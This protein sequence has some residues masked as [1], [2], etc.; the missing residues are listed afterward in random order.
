[1]PSLN[2]S[3]V[4]LAAVLGLGTAQARAG[5][6]ADHGYPNKPVRFLVPYA[7]G[8]GTDMMARYMAQKLAG[9]LAAPVIVDNR[10]GGGGLVG[11]ETAVR[12]APDGYTLVFDSAAYAT[13]AA[14]HEL[15]FDPLKDITPVA[16]AFTSGFIVSLH[17]SVPA[18]SVKELIAYAN[19]QQGKVNYGSSGVG[20]FSHLA[21][22]LFL[23]M[24]KTRMNHIAYRGTG[25]AVADLLGGQIQVVWG[26]LTSVVAQIKSQRLRGIAVTMGKRWNE[27]PDLPTVG[28]TVPNYEASVWYGIWG[29]RNLPPAIVSRINREARQIAQLPE[30]AERM[31]SEGVDAFIATPDQFRSLIATDLS[32][33]G[34]VVRATGLKEAVK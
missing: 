17:P 9:V 4:F 1:M 30:T 26:T 31:R 15:T 2:T 6:A 21:T 7:P 23:M 11:T 34:K 16:P 18:R 28:E 25:P 20:G 12:A 32:K 19:Q 27:M 5:T 10:P 8:G 3:T 29:P 33:W 22:E 24:S 14:L 13:R